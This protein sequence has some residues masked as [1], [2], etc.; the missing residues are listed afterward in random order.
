MARENKGYTYEEVYRETNIS[1]RYLQAL[2]TE[3]FSQFPGEPYLLG[4]LRSYADYLGLDP[5]ELVSLYRAMKIQEQPVPMEQLLK[6][7]RHFPWHAVIAGSVVV[8][9]IAIV[10]IVVWMNN[11]AKNKSQE[12]TAIRKPV[13]YQLSSGT[14][15]KRL[16][17][18]DSA[19]ITIGNERY[20]MNLVSLDDRVTL[21]SPSGTIIAELGQELS[22]DLNGDGQKDINLFVADLIKNK[23]DKGTVLRFTYTGTSINEEAAVVASENETA[24]NENSTPAQATS[25]ESSTTSVPPQNIGPVILSSSNP[26]PFTL[27]ATFRGNCLFR[28]ESDQKNRDERYFQKAEVLTIQAQNGIRLWISNASAVKI[29]VIGGGKTVDVEVGG[30]GEVVV[31]DVKWVKDAEGRYTLTLVQI[32]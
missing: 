32:D 15:E 9:A 24:T 17:I 25:S 30:P 31:T 12:V 7:E 8:I 27:Q 5:Q 16:Y 2:E 6:D 1:T 29:Q 22:I 21:S 26:Y 14:L 19:I 23:P 28:W 3:D 20:Q 4:F 13:S 11:S 10:G 18:G